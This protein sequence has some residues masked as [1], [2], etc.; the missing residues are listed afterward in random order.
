M[1]GRAANRTRADASWPKPHNLISPHLISHHPISPHLISHHL[2]PPKGRAPTEGDTRAAV[3]RPGGA[4]AR[5]AGLGCRAP[6]VATAASAPPGPHAYSC[7]CHC[8]RRRR[9]ARPTFL[10]SDYLG[11]CRGGGRGGYCGGNARVPGAAAAARGRIRRAAARGGRR[12]GGVRARR[13][14]AGAARVRSAARIS[15][16]G[17]RADCRADAGRRGRHGEVPRPRPCRRAGGCGAFVPPCCLYCA[18]ERQ[19]VSCL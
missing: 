19:G 6:R 3:P 1:D 16:R 13:G 7:N 4:P 11:G 12:G 18:V 17:G 8:N 9:P 5:R 14:G 10:R 2:I 15:G